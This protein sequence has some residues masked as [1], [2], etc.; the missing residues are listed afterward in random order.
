MARPKNEMLR[1]FVLRH[2]ETPGVAALAARRL[3]V[4]RAS[5]NLYLRDLVEEGLLD[6]SGATRGR[7]Y[8]L[9]TLERV[10]AGIDLSQQP[11]EDRLWRDKFCAPFTGLPSNVR[12]ICETGFSEIL[13][14]AIAH[15]K[16]RHA[17][18]L[19]KRDY[20]K[21]SLRIVDDGTGIFDRLARDC[22][23]GGR[24]EAVLE[25]AKG[26]L[27]AG[28]AGHAGQGIFFTARLFDVFTIVSG[29]LAF[30]VRRKS[31]GGHAFHVGPKAPDQK[32]TSVQM[33]IGTDASQT[34]AQTAAAHLGDA[35]D[36][37]RMTIPLV[38]AHDGGENLISRAQARRV[39]ARAESVTEV[40][41]DFSGVAEI[42]RQF[43]DEI[44]RA[45]AAAHPHVDLH[46]THASREVA[47]MIRQALANSGGVARLSL[48]EAG[49]AKAA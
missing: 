44:F 12:R 25:L 18:V 22:R 45:W 27:T 15:S 9:K 49:C 1:D 43:A 19:V 28:G 31:G 41:L 16:G 10:M 20:A 35:Q 4:T 14:N 26:A 34:I 23:L 21:A 46:A 33:E 40:V 11:Q 2:A 5:V 13:G 36:V 8:R 37:S 24:H 30:T 39:M 3:G 47:V 42:G 17:L 48:P 7:R 29:G 38:L 6:A 32:G